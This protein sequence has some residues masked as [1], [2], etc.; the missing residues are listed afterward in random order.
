ME[1]SKTPTRQVVIIQK[2][3]EKVT[4]SLAHGHL[5]LCGTLF[6]HLYDSYRKHCVR[7]RPNENMLNKQ[8]HFQHAFI[9][10][11]TFFCF[12][13]CDKQPDFFSGAAHGVC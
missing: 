7:Q 2:Q 8:M 9:N 12:R 3:W 4:F 13:L 5:E 6:W 10:I 1:E 11:Y